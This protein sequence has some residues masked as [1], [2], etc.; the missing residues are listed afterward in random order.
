MLLLAGICT[1]CLLSTLAT[2]FCIR[3]FIGRAHRWSLLDH[4]NSRSSHSAPTPR[5]AGLFFLPIVFITGLLAS[6]WTQPQISTSWLT[7]SVICAAALT[8]LGFRDD[9]A[10][11]SS[12]LRFTLQFLLI[13]PLVWMGPE[14]SVLNLPFLPV[15]E[16][17]WT[18]KV[19]LVFWFVG[20]INVYNF[21]DGIDGIA[22]TQGVVVSAGNLLLALHTG[23]VFLAL[24]SMALLGA[25]IGFLI[26][27][28][29]PAKVFM[30]DGGAYFL[31]FIFAW[32]PVAHIFSRPVDLEIQDTHIYAG[33]CLLLAPFLLDG[34]FTF[35]R[36]LAHGENVFAAHCSHRFQRLVQAGYTHSQVSLLYFCWAILTIPGVSLAWFN[37]KDWGLYVALFIAIVAGIGVHAL[38]WKF[39][40]SRTIR[41]ERIHTTLHKSSGPECR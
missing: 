37:Y 32:L 7:Y 29:R 6:I 20:M 22:G 36:R 24:I 30:G 10:S 13:I 23:S 3:W 5:G 38:A 15:I 19:L 18:G 39:P 2:Y 4:P 9:V 14:W 34:G 41:K 26:F 21:M 1:A 35:L 40:N 11:L 31:G 12:R 33:F 28:W 8:I 27:N 17:G 16:W 25:L